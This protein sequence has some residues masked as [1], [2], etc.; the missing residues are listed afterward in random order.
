[1]DHNRKK[2]KV[3]P[4]GLLIGPWKNYVSELEYKTII[5]EALTNCVCSGNPL[6]EIR[7]YL[8]TRRRV[9][10][11]LKTKFEELNHF[12][13][14]FYEYVRVHV[15][16]LLREEYHKTI[17]EIIEIEEERIK[18]FDRFSLQNSYFTDL[19]CGK[20]VH[21][22][23]YDPQLERLKNFL[24]HQRYCSL[25]DYSGKDAKGPVIMNI[26]SCEMS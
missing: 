6:I 11:V 2:I 7:G 13:H 15:L 14:K 23:Y 12:L 25:V 20:K 22:P 19:L 3:Q 18:L 5:C 26:Q 10:L 16:R 8:I 1:M 4:I 21:L 9:F 17:G 24:T